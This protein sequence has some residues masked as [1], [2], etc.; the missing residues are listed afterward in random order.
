MD[1]IQQNYEVYVKI[2]KQNRIIAINSSA[3]LDNVEAWIKI[4]EGLGDKYHHAQNH[5]FD[6]PIFTNYGV[7][8]C[9]LVDGKAVERTEEEINADKPKPSK[10]QPTVKELQEQL[11]Q[12]QL[13]L[14]EIYEMMLAGG[15]Q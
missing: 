6:K 2:D 3:F 5:Y 13:A 1:F 9:K 11:L 7:P 15:A 14:T 8:R 4:D 10:P 12:T